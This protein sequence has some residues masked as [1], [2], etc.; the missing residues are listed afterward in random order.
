MLK[1]A[2]SQP[3]N[4]AQ[5]KRALKDGAIYR[6][7]KHYIRD[8]YSGQIRTVQHSGSTIFYSGLYNQPES[9]FS[10]LNGGRGIYTQFGS[11]KDWIFADCITMQYKGNPI[12]QLEI[13][14]EVE[15]EPAEEKQPEPITAPAPK[16][17]PKTNRIPRKF[18]KL[19]ITILKATSA[20]AAGEKATV[21]RDKYGRLIEEKENGEMYLA[22]L[23]MLRAAEIV[24][25]DRIE[26]EAPAEALESPTTPAAISD[27]ETPTEEA[28]Q[29]ENGTETATGS[30]ETIT[31]RQTTTAADTEPQTGTETA[32]TDADRESTTTHGRQAEEATETAT[33]TTRADCTTDSRKQAQTTT[34]R[35]DCTP[36]ERPTTSPTESHR[37]HDR[38][39]GDQQTTHGHREPHRATER[40]TAAATTTPPHDRQTAGATTARGHPDT[41]R[42]LFTDPKHIK[43]IIWYF[44][45]SF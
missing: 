19:Y 17:E 6:I 5:L 7:I 36:T 43:K 34:A 42:S 35:A 27:K 31:D 3:A 1:R 45:T 41:R 15:E 16:A 14:E 11:A 8:E 44:D 25:I 13:L 29:P 24:R 37:T 12:M 4:L 9:D 39:T 18:Y 33:E 21:Y 30:P 20:N 2:I 23:S 40:A 28:T 10:K 32:T 38:T 26:T 22:N